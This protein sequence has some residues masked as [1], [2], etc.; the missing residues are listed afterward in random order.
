MP[1]RDWFCSSSKTYGWPNFMPISDLTNKT[2]GY[3]V[4]DTVIV[5]A[6]ITLISAVKNLS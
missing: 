3:I 5:E 4:N 6:D 2:K 1:G